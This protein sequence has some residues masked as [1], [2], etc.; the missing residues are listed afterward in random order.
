[1]F[2]YDASM[3]DLV[4]DYCR[5][6]L[7]F[8]PVS[9]DLPGHKAT[10]DRVLEGLLGPHG[11]DLPPCSSCSRTI[12]PPPSSPATAPGSSRSYLPHRR[13]RRCCSTWSCRARRCRGRH[14][15][16]PPG[17]RRR[18]RDHPPDRRPGRPAPL[19]GRVLRVGRVGRQSVV[20]GGGARHRRPPGVHRGRPGAGGGQRSGSLVDPQR[21]VGH[22]RRRPHC[23]HARPAPD[24][25]RPG[26][27][28]GRGRRRGWPGVAEVAA[29]S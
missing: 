12:W 22:R 4:F 21:L 11:N 20:A 18:E 24:R 2:S 8:D 6:R 17:R 25:S 23:A 28:S 29:G 16:R 7:R 3:T 14:G 1:M 15:W 13:R 27:R 19:G 10:L 5:E 26:R 9:L